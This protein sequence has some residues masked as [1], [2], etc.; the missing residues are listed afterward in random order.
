MA[1]IR[2]SHNYRN[3]KRYRQILGVLVRYG[4]GDI[5]SRLNLGFFLK[6]LK[7]KSLKKDQFEKISTAARLR[8]VFEELGPTFV[9]LGQILSVRPD[10][11]PQNYIVELEKLQDNVPPFPGAQAQHAIESQFGKDI[12]QL[13]SFFDITPIASASIAQVHR[14]TTK[15]QTEVIVKIRRPNIQQIIDTDLQILSE[16]ARLIERNVPESHLFS[17]GRIVT[18]FSR[19]IRNELNLYREAQNIERFRKNFAEENTV[20]IPNVYWELTTE[21]ILT[22]DYIQGIKISDTTALDAAGLD[23]KTIA[24]NGAQLILKQIFEHGFFHADPHPGNIFVLPGNVIAPLDFGMVG[25]LDEVEMETVSVLLTA[26]IKK[27]VKRIIDALI[28]FG[29][30][31]QT[32]DVRELKLDLTEFIDRYYQVPLRQLN[33]DTI[34]TEVIAIMRRYQ[35]SL[36]AELALMGKT[37]ITEEAIGL[38]LDP[39]FDMVSLAKPYVEKML[40]RRLDPR[41]QLKEFADII[42]DFIRLLKSL[43]S[44]LKLIMAKIKQGE[45][46]IQFEHRGLEQHVARLNQMG[47]RLAFSLIVT[48]LVIGSSLI[49]HSGKGPQIFDLSIFGI[50]GYLIAVFFGLWLVI[51][52]IRN[53]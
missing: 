8:M 32:K 16:L 10:I 42:D 39:D 14:A 11:L 25:N 22:M 50:T 7:L 43:P 9:K 29:V 37:L 31:D 48:G 27:D 35:I 17:P 44:D 38:T 3:I 1:V 19:T 41:R 52:I 49:I 4:F 45:I 2:L 30:L 46:K 24:I 13:F 21:Q 36:P 26:F 40:L 12:D 51:N 47:N 34:L 20:Y 15:Q 28:N 18:E 5:I 53:R 23:R 6:S 33:I